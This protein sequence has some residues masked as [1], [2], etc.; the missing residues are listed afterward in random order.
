MGAPTLWLW[1][2]EPDIQMSPREG[3]KKAFQESSQRTVL[4]QHT[5]P[6]ASHFLS[7]KH[8]R[9]RN[10]N[11]QKNQPTKNH[12]YILSQIEDE[13]AVLM[14]SLYPTI[15]LSCL[16][17]QLKKAWDRYR[18]WT[19]WVPQ[20]FFA[21]VHSYLLQHWTE[22]HCMWLT[23]TCILKSSHLSPNFQQQLNCVLGS[24][25]GNHILAS[26]THT[27][28]TPMLSVSR[29]NQCLWTPLLSLDS[30]GLTLVTIFIA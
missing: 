29:P 22:V 10:K 13:L 17:L 19:H 8:K 24:S 27:T 1:E 23:S 15:R 2:Q 4:P 9:G 12:L 21:R 11:K 5:L 14:S 7:L 30:P 26:P 3:Q 6:Q 28:L 16:V 25:S 20:S 18:G